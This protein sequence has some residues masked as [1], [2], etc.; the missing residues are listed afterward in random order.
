VKADLGRLQR[1]LEV[2]RQLAKVAPE[3]TLEILELPPPPKIFE[4]FAEAFGG[5]RLPD[6][7]LPE[8]E[9]ALATPELRETLMQTVHLLAA[10]QETL[11]ALLPV[12][13]YLY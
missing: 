7:A 5:T 10:A 8:L 11:V 13:V 9:L 3:D 6:L 4:A 1:A 2:A 12:A